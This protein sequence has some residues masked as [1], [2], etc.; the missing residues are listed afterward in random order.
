MNAVKKILILGTIAD[1]GLSLLKAKKNLQLVQL[2][3]KEATDEKQITRHLKDSN[4]L[5]VRTQTIKADWLDNAPALEIIS[6]HGV[7]KN[8][9]WP[10]IKK[11]WYG[12][13]RLRPIPAFISGR[14]YCLWLARRGKKKS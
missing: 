10:L 2:L 12:I 1:A 6:R 3:G 5:L 9:L 11:Y 7:G 8:S 4:A 13:P 14:K